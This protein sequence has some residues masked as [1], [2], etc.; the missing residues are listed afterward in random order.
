MKKPIWIATPTEFV[1]DYMPWA[2]LE[3]ISLCTPLGIPAMLLCILA[4]YARHRGNITRAQTCSRAALALILCGFAIGIAV[5][6][7]LVF[8]D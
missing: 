7:L 3:L 4:S 5:K 6:A 8:A 1:P 2:I